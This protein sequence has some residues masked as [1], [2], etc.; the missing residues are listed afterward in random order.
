MAAL[1][2]I[3]DHKDIILVQAIMLLENN[4]ITISTVYSFRTNSPI[5]REVESFYKQNEI[6]L[7]QYP[8]NNNGVVN[9]EK[10]YKELEKQLIEDFYEIS[11]DEKV[12]YVFVGGGHKFC[13]L[14]LQKCATIFGA[15]DIFHMFFNGERGTEPVYISDINDA[16]KNKKLL[17]ASLGQ[18]RGWPA[19]NLISQEGKNLYERVIEIGGKL[20]SVTTDSVN[21]YPFE[22]ITLLPDKAI[23][24][25][26]SQLTDE[27]VD[28][29]IMLPKTELHCHLGGFAT[30][31]KPLESVRL[32]A[33][34]SIPDTKPI[35]NPKGWPFPDRHI[36]LQA[37]MNLGDNNGSTLLKDWGCLEKQ[38]ELMYDY[39]LKEN[40]RYAEVRCSPNNY[41]TDKKNG[42]EVTEFIQ[43]CFNKCMDKAL[44]QK[45]SFC[46]VNIL[47]IGTRILNNIKDSVKAHIDIAT[48][49]AAESPGI[50]KCSVVGMDLAGYEHESTRAEYYQSDFSPIHRKG[51]ALTIHAGENDDAE[52]I[53][54]AI[55]QLNTRRIGHGLHLY[56]SEPLIRSVINRKIGVEM[57][58]YAN[59]QIKGFF[60]MADKPEYPVLDY[61]YAG[62]QVTINTDNIGISSAGLTENYMLLVKLV[63]EIKRMDVLKMIR[64]GIDQA[65]V[66]YQHKQHLFKYFNQRI[67]EIMYEKAK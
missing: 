56:Q 19:I 10:A 53:W 25:L 45:K 22:C 24:W 15:D 66:T 29:I 20:T 18:E 63:P 44:K 40:I 17:Y 35:E 50:P 60:P 30:F 62:V 28:W 36:D 52:G 27:D 55:F 8:L 33:L 42:I 41:A 37:Y 65:F 43:D 38:I 12:K 11:K 39:F 34:H 2:G 64:N 58:P 13:S 21:E 4:G 67:F 14:A 3:V 51:I 5:D 61:L 32:A 23:Y 57:C 31:G 54:Q 46:H 1:I 49:L 47:I 7:I 16:I 48:H 59:Y 6:T 9:T 26:E